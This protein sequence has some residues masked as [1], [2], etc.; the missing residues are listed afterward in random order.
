[1]VDVEN[2]FPDSVGDLENFNWAV[3]HSKAREQLVFF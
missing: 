3:T 2:C 1:M